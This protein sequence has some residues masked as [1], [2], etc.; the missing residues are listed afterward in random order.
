MED[1]L[2]ELE[3]GLL[4]ADVA[5]DV[6]TKIVESVKE[7]L[8]GQKIKRG[9]DVEEYTINALKKAISLTLKENQ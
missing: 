1:I 9:S 2:F 4:E 8:V 3:L 6:A 7:D 5:M